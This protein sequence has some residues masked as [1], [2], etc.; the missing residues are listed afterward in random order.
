MVELAFE[1]LAVAIAI[2]AV[3]FLATLVTYTIFIMIQDIRQ[4]KNR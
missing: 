2:T 3:V 1:I 4:E